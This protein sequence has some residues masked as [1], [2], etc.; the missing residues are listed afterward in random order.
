MKKVLFIISYFG[1]FNNY[2]QIFLDSCKNNEKYNWLIITDD[3][4]KY[5]FPENVDVIYDTFQNFKNKVQ[6]KINKIKISL[7]N[8]YKLCDF[9]PTYGY[10]FEDYVKD[11]QYWGYCDTDLIF[12]NIERCLNL[13]KLDKFD[14]I[15]V[16]GHFTIF[17]NTKEIRELFLED[18]RYKEVLSSSKNLKFDEEFGEDFGFSINN[19][20]EKNNKKIIALDNF[21]D[22]YVKSSNFKITHYNADAKEYYTEKY[23][24]NCF[25]YNNGEL[26]CYSIDKSKLN[27]KEY[28]Y[29]H[30]QKRKMKIK[31]NKYN[32]YK[33]IPNSFEYLEKKINSVKDFKS[34]KIKNFNLHYFKIRLKNLKLKIQKK[35]EVK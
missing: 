10:I 35:L 3:K 34:I 25:V 15:G 11:F 12:G 17:K 16:L 26:K 30:L 21:A 4:T 7:D 32:C 2:F 19:I 31:I 5:I 1:E 18:E 29:I 9:K 23:K 27:I 22:I 24:K 6:T 13:E 20:F 28:M 33:I 8:P 14:K